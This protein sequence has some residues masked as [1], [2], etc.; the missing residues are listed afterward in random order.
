MKGKKIR[1]N[2]IEESDE[3]IIYPYDING[4]L[5]S[6]KHIKTNFPLAYQYLSDKINKKIL[7]D[8]ENGRFK[9][10][11]WSYSRPQNMKILDK[12][13]ILTPFNAFS[14]SY[15][16]DKTGN[17]IFSAGVSGAYGILLKNDAVISYEYLLG[18]LNSSVL[19][20]YLKIISTA[21]RGGFYSYENKY[22]KQL[23]IY[24]PNK[25]D[26]EKYALCQNIEEM[27]KKVLEYKREGKHREDADYLERK[28][29]ELVEKIY[30]EPVRKL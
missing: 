3:F 13:K 26:Q 22:I 1:K 18:L 6:E 24:I 21:L 15:C 8:R 28:I 9:N 30:L 19:D 29:D 10:I 16:L 25:D 11:W 2:R 7:F 23:P 20:K 12:I 27:V 17:F 4:I 5:M 14:S